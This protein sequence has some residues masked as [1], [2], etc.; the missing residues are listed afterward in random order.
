MASSEMAPEALQRYEMVIGGER[1]GA[2]DG[3][4]FESVDPYRGVAWA[5]APDAGA[6]DVD[7]AV[8]A[9]HAA[10][11]G[12]W[13]QMAGRERAALMRRLADILVRDA[14]ELTLIESRDN[15]K[16]LS[17]ARA[18]VSYMPEWFYY[19]SG[20]ADK[21]NGES[22]DPQS[23]SYLA[24][25]RHEPIGVVAA[26]TPWNS[27]LMLL[28]W[29]LAPALAAGCTFVVKPSDHTPITTL[30]LAARFEEAGFPPGV[31]NVVTGVGPATGEALTAHRLVS[32]V[33]FTGSTAVG[34]KVAQSAMSHLARVSLELGGKSAQVIFADA[35]LEAA[36]N[37]VIAGVF[38]ATGQTC[39]AGS[40]LLIQREIHDEL[41]ERVAQRARTIVV[42]DPTDDATEMGPLANQAQYDR[43]LGFVDRARNEGATVLCGGGPHGDGS[44]YLVQPTILRDVT[45]E[46]EVAREEVFGPVVAAMPFDT[47]EE[48]IALANATDYGLAGSVWTRDVQRAHRV[49]HQLQTGTVWINTYRVIA[50]GVPFGGFKL[51]GYGRESGIEAVREFTETKAIWIE[52]TGATRDP[53][54]IG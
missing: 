23:R 25:T 20:L 9:A 18:Q 48:A 52:L 51:S 27:P 44:G 21:L 15:G 12:P 19:F 32:K 17:D 46:M 30:E 53:F 37:G 1:V 11:S 10:L 36:A 22:I 49:A 24:Y 8:Q 13:G 39:M 40:R 29:K 14:E 2:A 34:I 41:L 7:R 43:V 38:A 45:P 47:E 5:T 26:I 6:E 35:D 16:L 4:E 28:A 31:F 42:G 3:R 54:T 33:A 50:P